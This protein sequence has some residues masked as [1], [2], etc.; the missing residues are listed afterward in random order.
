VEPRI[1]QSENMGSETRFFYKKLW[2]ELVRI[3]V[4]S[5]LAVY[6]QSHRLGATPLETHDQYFFFQL[7]TCSHSPYATSSLTRERVCRLHFLQTLASAVILRSES[8][9]TLDYNLL[10]QI[11]HSLNLAGQVTVF[12][13][14]RNRIAQLCRHALSS[15]FA[16]SYDSQGDGAGIRTPGKTNRLLPF[17][18]QGPY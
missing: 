4:T 14:P 7:S 3:R 9:G 15:L 6:R 16:V 11:P 1:P 13:S 8:C 17:I 10:S 5:R 12:T 2:E 18:R